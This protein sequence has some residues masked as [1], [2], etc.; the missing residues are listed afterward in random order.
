[1]TII[2]VSAK[3]K[4]RIW[5]FYQYTR[6]L[7]SVSVISNVCWILY[8]NNKVRGYGRGGIGIKCKLLHLDPLRGFLEMLGGGTAGGRLFPWGVAGAEPDDPACFCLSETTLIILTSL[9]TSPSTDGPFFSLAPCRTIMHVSCTDSN[10]NDLCNFQWYFRA[11]QRG[12]NILSN[13]IISPFVHNF[14]FLNI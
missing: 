12:E 2:V 13:H 14:A 10:F 1:M 4:Y 5:L 6:Q 9:N 8:S 3:I 7:T 11:F